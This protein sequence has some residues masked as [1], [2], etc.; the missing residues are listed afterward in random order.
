MPDE[1]REV[2]VREVPVGISTDGDGRTIEARIVPYNTPTR[3]VDLPENGGTG[4][5]Y[6]ATF[7]P[8]AFAKQTS[9]VSRIKVWLNFEHEKGLRGIVGHGAKLED[10]EDALYGT[11]RVHENSDGDKALQM[12]R[13]GLTTGISLEATP[14]R[15]RRVGD[16]V[17]RVRVHLEKVSLCR[18]GAY[19]D[20]LVLAVREQ[21]EPD[22]DDEP[23]EPG[24]EEI[25]EPVP[26][27][28]AVGP[29]EAELALARVGWTPLE[30]RAVTRKPWVSSPARFEDGEY[31]RSCLIVREGDGPVAERCSLPVLEPNGDVNANALAHAA[32]VL[33]GARGGLRNVSPDVKAA[34]ARKLMRLYNQAE[35]DAPTSV[36]KAA[37]R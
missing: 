3:V 22:P 23:D 21:P 17:E 36:R 11:F 9:A 8:G 15:S 20:A 7:L 24:T 16:V 4:I 32:A 30:V 12:V 6:Y 19:E 27:S 18:M 28:P 1:T 5:P 33:A 29:S 26:T 2:L 37:T 35:I 31:E 14:L 10:R 34:A 13:D 25:P